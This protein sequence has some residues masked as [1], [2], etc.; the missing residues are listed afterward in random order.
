[1]TQRILSRRAYFPAL[2]LGWSRLGAPT[3]Q[4]PAR[5]PGLR[6]AALSLPLPA[7]CQGASPVPVGEESAQ[8][9][10]DP[11][12]VPA[13]PSHLHQLAPRGRW[14]WPRPRVCPGTTQTHALHRDGSFT[15]LIV[16][17][18]CS[19]EITC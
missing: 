17:V 5:A 15:P 16:A 9:T 19:M 13:L 4:L 2:A 12:L 14:V 1:M 6:A 18:V 8:S 10:E 11:S 7:G 3:P